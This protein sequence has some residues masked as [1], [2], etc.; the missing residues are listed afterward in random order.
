LENN[1]VLVKAASIQ[2]R[3]RRASLLKIEESG[4]RNI[5]KQKKKRVARWRDLGIL[6]MAKL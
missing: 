2:V 6:Q 1:I 3:T 4:I 5:S